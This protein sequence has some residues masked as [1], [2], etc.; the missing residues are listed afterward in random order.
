MGGAG[1]LAAASMAAL[2]LARSASTSA[3][4]RFGIVIGLSGTSTV[5]DE[6][7]QPDSGIKK[8]ATRKTQKQVFETNAVPEK[9]DF[10]LRDRK[11]LPT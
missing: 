7:P 9:F 11:Y 4:E 8:G 6:G 5:P 10:I 1:A 2:I 3:S